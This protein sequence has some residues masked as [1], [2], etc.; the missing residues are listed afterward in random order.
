MTRC[1]HIFLA[2][3]T[4]ALLTGGCGSDSGLASLRQGMAAFDEGNY[5]GAIPHLKQAA[6]RMPD[7]AVVYYHLGVAHLEQGEMDAATAALNA[8]LE[9]DPT[10]ARAQICLGQVAYHKSA[11]AEARKRFRLAQKAQD[12]ETQAAA[13]NGLA[14]VEAAE[15]RH[16]MARLNLLKALRLTPYPPAF[17][18]LASY[19]RD[20]FNLRQDALDNFEMYLRVA[21]K[22][23]AHHRKAENNV[24]SLRAALERTAAEQRGT[25]RDEAAATRLIGEAIAAQNANQLTR[26]TR[27][28]REALAADP[29]A[30]N[31]AYGLGM[32]CKRLGQ[33]AEALEA[34]KRAATLN[35]GHQDSYLE[36]AELAFGLRRYEEAAKILDGAI[37]RNP[38]NAASAEL[39]V[40]IR[41]AEGRHGEARAYGEYYLS[42]LPAD[43]KGRDVYAAWLSDLPVE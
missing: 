28:Y 36:A 33:R 23:D 25:R 6:K 30:F 11:F 4:A 13:L 21:D 18:N 10:H 27:V 5:A 3:G 42:L 15:E 34:F 43:A 7:A 9:L 41:H 35:P 8:A 32:T 2:L 38:R 40:K 31:A 17:Y 29:L 12:K 22:G 14:M 20:T 39:M 19:Y 1:K 37:A 26:A 24:A 16:D